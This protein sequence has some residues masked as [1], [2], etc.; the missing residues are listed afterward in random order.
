MRHTL[1]ILAAHLIFVC[2][3]SAQQS[4]NIEIVD[5]LSGIANSNNV[6]EN[7]AAS[8]ARLE[9]F[10]DGL[11]KA[12][13]FADSLYTE[14]Q[15]SNTYLEIGQEDKAIELAQRMLANIGDRTS[16]D[17]LTVMRTLALA[18]LRHGERIN[19]LNDHSAESC[20]FPIKGQGLQKNTDATK[21]A[22]KL[23]EEILGRDNTD[24]N[25][26]WLLNLANMAIGE[27]PGGVHASFLIPHLDK[28]S[29][30]PI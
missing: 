27:Y 8:E 24:M 11:A 10:I 21:K 16:E 30:L 3:S 6:P 2:I 29:S 25:S 15:M 7:P 5:L 22:I 12:E 4:T 17:G 19:C 18:Y 26:R 1:C 20:I 23:Y 28:H 13:H 14:Y 9:H